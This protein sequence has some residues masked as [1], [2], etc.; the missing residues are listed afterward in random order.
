MPDF[1]ANE[2]PL[3]GELLSID[4][5]KQYARTLAKS[6]QVASMAGPNLLLPRLSANKKI[7]Q[8]YNEQT[9]L[10]EKRRRPGD[11]ENRADFYGLLRQHRLTK[12]QGDRAGSDVNFD[13]GEQLHHSLQILGC[14]FSKELVSSI[15]LTDWSVNSIIVACGNFNKPNGRMRWRMIQP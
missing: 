3:R 5:L 15:S 8:D 2:Q 11:G 7:L 14:S 9:L 1:S 4:L 12:Q 10:A 6:R 13:C